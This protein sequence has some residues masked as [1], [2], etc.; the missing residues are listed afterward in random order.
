MR[1]EAAGIRRPFVVCLAALGSFALLAGIAGTADAAWDGTATIKLGDSFG[2]E[3]TGIPEEAHQYVFYAP[4]GT[5]LSA[6]LKALPGGDLVPQLS[7]LTEAGTEVD[8]GAALVGTTIK[9]YV[10]TASGRFA[11]R[12][13]AQSGTGDYMLKTKAKC[14]SKLGGAVAASPY[15]FPA[16]RGTLL[17]ATIKAAKGSGAVPSFNT[18]T[19][20]KGAVDVGAGGTKLANV[21]LPLDGSYSLG[22]ANTGAAGD[23]LLGVKLKAPKA[24][25]TYNFGGMEDV[26]GLADAMRDKWMGSGHADKFAQPFTYAS[27]LSTSCGKCHGTYG[28]RDF[29]GADGTAAGVVDNV[30]PDFSVITCNACHNSAT[31]VLTSVTF[32][33]GLV[34]SGLGRESRCMVCHQGRESGVSVNTAIGASLDDDKPA[35]LSFKNVHYFA[36]GATQFGRQAGG[37]YEFAG[38]WYDGKFTHVS[39]ADACVECHDPHSLEV[40]VDLCV[41]CHTGMTGADYAAKLEKAKDVRMKAT[42]EDYDDDGDVAEGVYHEIHGLADRLLAAIYATATDV[43]GQAIVYGPDNYPYWFKDL[44]TD[45]VLD[46]G[47]ENVS[48]N[49]YK[50]W[51]PRLLRA[52]YNYQFWKKDPGGF[53]HNGKYLIQLLYDSLEHLD[54]HDAVTV[55]DMADLH[56]NDPGH[57]DSSAMPFRDWDDS[58]TGMV[59]A[60]CSRCHSTEGFNFVVTNNLDNTVSRPPVDGFSC[61]HC[62]VG[63]DFGA[64][65]PARK[66]IASV[67]FPSPIEAPV[68]IAN[69][70]A[71][72][73]DSFLCMTCHRG[74]ESK[75]TVDA[76][77]AKGGSSLGFKNVHYLPAG[78]MQY[79]NVAKVGYEY[80]GK[81]YAGKWAHPGGPGS[82][83]TTC[84]ASD[85]SFEPQL[86]PNCA[87]CHAEA[88]GDIEKIRLNRGTDYDG[89]GSATEKLKDEVAG[90]QSRLMTAIQ[91]YVLAKGDPVN[92]PAIAYSSTSYP[93]W[94]TDTNGN[95][96]VDAGETTKYPKWDAAMMKA[97]FN[98]QFSI[99]DPGSWAHNTPYVLQLL[100]DSIEDVGGNV[101][102]LTRP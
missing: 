34:A 76:A 63:G 25:R 39:Q 9:K 82:K 81:T 42:L 57:F 46:E 71:D 47:V 30:P 74:R 77:I 92:F 70:A 54:A 7:L 10:F 58:A 68:T 56:R 22:W 93:Y 3:I 62:H 36:A 60:S 87:F 52:A 49:G 100:H 50:S 98:Y 84:H 80:T 18:L 61:E 13:T 15:A 65:S 55:S 72:P 6:A 73:D 44:D 31:A 26:P 90:F 78:A 91:A 21:R 1:T 14:P 89:D 101:T 64:A 67:T 27:T 85:H 75:A 28:Y 59:P 99:K 97:A 53:A 95:G 16:V 35:A 86:G 24:P 32:P 41:T 51:S 29:L 4:Q 38:K 48:A 40:K 8:L 96:V 11:L 83:C 102:G 94:F 12:V 37:G 79:G 2:A 5:S 33:S 20:P 23:V 66:Y 88:A 45:G 43:N 17:S 19:G 69:N